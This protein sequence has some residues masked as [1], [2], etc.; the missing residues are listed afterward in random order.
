VDITVPI[1][2]PS[3]PT[4][5]FGPDASDPLEQALGYAVQSFQ[6]YLDRKVVEGVEFIYFLSYDVWDG[7]LVYDG[8]VRGSIEQR[9]IDYV[10]DRSLNND[11]RRSRFERYQNLKES[12]PPFKLGAAGRCFGEALEVQHEK[13]PLSR[14][15]YVGNL[16]AYAS[17]HA[18][19]DQLL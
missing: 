9:L 11:R 6:K 10:R 12:E 18:P 3:S 19:F 14:V 4:P 15:W 13:P 17:E 1:S 8:L 2:P 5:P 16:P 7:C